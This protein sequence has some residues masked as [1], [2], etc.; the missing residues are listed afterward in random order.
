MIQHVQHHITDQQA[1]DICPHMKKYTG[2]QI[3]SPF[4]DQCEKQSHNSCI[5][6][7]E[8]IHMVNSKCQSW[9]QCSCDHAHIISHTKKYQPAENNLFCKRCCN[10]HPENQTPDTFPLWNQGLS[11]LISFRIQILLKKPYQNVSIL[12]KKCANYKKPQNFR[13]RKVTISCRI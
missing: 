11:F 8:Q 5:H 7:L 10:P 4:Q 2:K 12:T 6:S 3:S 13:N 1:P 9:K